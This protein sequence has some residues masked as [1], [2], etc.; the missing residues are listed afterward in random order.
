[1]RLTFTAL[2]AVLAFSSI[3]SAADSFSLK[4]GDRV[5]FY[6]DSITDQRLYTVITET[7]AVTRYPNLNVTFVHSGWGGDKVSGGGGGP[8]DLR[9]QRDVFAYKP[10][11]MTIMLGMNDGLYKPETEANDHVYFDGMR[12]IV[13]S[14]KASSPG[15]RITLIEPS[16]YDDVTRLPT[17][18]GGYNEVLLSFS[19]WLT[20]YASQNGLTV[21]DF[22]R[23]M[24]AMLHKADELG[25]EDALK[26]L[27]DRV[28]P[29][30][31]GHLVMAEQL[32]KAWNA[33]PVVAS[34]SIRNSGGNPTLKTAEHAQVT[35]LKNSQGT[36]SWTET[37]DALPLPFKQWEPSFGT[38]PLPLVLKSSDVTD[39]LNQE[40]LIITGLHSGVYSIKIDGTTVGTFNDDEF[41]R[42]VNLAILKTPMSDQA[43]QV[44]DLT[45]S[46]C[47]IHNERWRTVQVPL[48]AEN[49]PEVPADLAAA[50][51][52]EQ[53]VINKRRQ[54]AQ[55][56]SHQFEIVAVN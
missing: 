4:D 30:F 29:S 16:S 45:V 40:P 14:V 5:V 28:H 46:H 1:L 25:H 43:K 26:I 9:L 2:C 55:P 23:P 15:V 56:K 13:E 32:L 6:G 31:A 49:L 54:I 27:P 20:N 18:P 47:D 10:T 44:Y 12:H 38:G 33:R 7:Y 8:I 48:S 52:L 3:S 11:V 34:V 24:T 17:F 50:D 42:G 39:A 53:A 21:A 41:A 19:K 37:D 51:A 22:N 35:E 36:L